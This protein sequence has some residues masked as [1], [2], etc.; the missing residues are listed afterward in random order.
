MPLMTQYIIPKDGEHEFN[1]E[2]LSREE[3][4]DLVPAG[5]SIEFVPDRTKLRRF[6][7][8]GRSKIVDEDKNHARQRKNIDTILGS[9]HFRAYR[10][11]TRE[12]YSVNDIAGFIWL[13]ET[14]L[15][16]FEKDF[17]D[18]EHQTG[19]LYGTEYFFK[20]FCGGDKR[21]QKK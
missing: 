3:T 14:E 7:S 8:D 21:C 9:L 2:E 19:R 11:L 18:S 10:N 5:K 17:K 13:T 1:L 12:G 6:Y 20:P 4:K 15:K 16:P